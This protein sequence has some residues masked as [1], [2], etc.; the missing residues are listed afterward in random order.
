MKAKQSAS[1]IAVGPETMDFM[2]HGYTLIDEPLNLRDGGQRWFKKVYETSCDA[3]AGAGL[4]LGATAWMGSL[5]SNN[6][7]LVF[8]IDVSSMMLQMAEADLKKATPAQA[9]KVRCIQANWQQLPALPAP[10]GIAVGDNSFSF[11]PYPEG[12]AQMCDELADRMAPQGLLITRFL[13]LP[14][15]HERASADQIVKA[16]TLRPTINY[17]ELRATLLFGH[18]DERTYAI[19]TESVL[20]EFDANRNLFDGLLRRF[21]APLQNDLLTIDK[22]RSAGA[23]YY[24][25]PLASVL[26]LMAKRFRII[27]AHFGPYAMSEY[28]PLIVAARR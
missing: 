24:A 4:V 20:A 25:P 1:V 6:Q 17:T 7:P 28:F 11:L 14:Q 8:M 13:S 19:D 21:N 10:I 26:S 12:W 3:N 16:F 18:C 9:A 5:L 23:V 27:A 22:Y 2:A 15:D